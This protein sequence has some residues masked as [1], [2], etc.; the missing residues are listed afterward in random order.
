MAPGEI[1]D[2]LVTRP[3]LLRR[4]YWNKREKTAETFLGDWIRTGD[5]YRLDEEGYWVYCGRSDD[6]LKV[7]GQCVSPFEVEA[8]LIAHPAVLEAAVVGARRRATG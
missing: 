8:A 5:K 6:M 1:G 7:S 2:L 3:T 4:Y